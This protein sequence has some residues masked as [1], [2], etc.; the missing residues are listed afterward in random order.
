MTL[1]PIFEKLSSVIVIVK[2]NVIVVFV[3][4]LGC[5][6]RPKAVVRY[7]NRGCQACLDRTWG[8]ALEQML[9]EHAAQARVFSVFVENLGIRDNVLTSI[10]RKQGDFSDIAK[11]IKGKH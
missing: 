11:K 4:F 7:W 10:R 5:A 1:T 9:A 6:A 8:D 3:V 2:V